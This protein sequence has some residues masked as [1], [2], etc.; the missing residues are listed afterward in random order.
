MSE[1]WGKDHTRHVVATNILRR[2]AVKYLLGGSKGMSDDDQSEL[3][4]LNRQKTVQALD[5]MAAGLKLFVEEQLHKRYRT[6]WQDNIARIPGH[7][8]NLEDPYIL[9]ATIDKCWVSVF[10]TCLKVP[11]SVIEELQRDRNAA[12]HHDGTFG[13]EKVNN[14]ISSMLRLIKSIPASQKSIKMV[15]KIEASTVSCE[16]SYFYCWI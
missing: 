12:T 14:S 5:Y 2:N 16:Q 4:M 7:A 3:E 15:E 9:L 13:A 10:D 8:P 1:S 6:T 11:R